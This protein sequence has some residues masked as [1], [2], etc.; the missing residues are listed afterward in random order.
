MKAL[1]IP[2]FLI[3]LLL[4]S[5]AFFVDRASDIP[6]VMK[7]VAP[8]YVNAQ[9]GIQT[10][11]QTK[12][13]EPDDKGFSELAQ[14]FR[15]YLHSPKSPQAVSQI[16]IKRLTRGNVSLS[17]GQNS[18]EEL[19]PIGV[20]LSNG[21]ELTLNIS[22]LRKDIAALQNKNLFLYAFITFFSGVLI[23]CIAFIIERSEN[24]RPNPSFHSDAPPA[25]GCHPL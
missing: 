10:L 6:H 14:V 13:L 22:I 9:L 18:V 8:A 24:K 15:K 12:M 4:A 16:T 20:F 1:S 19:I 17:F 5:A 25:S 3:G 7:I 23:Q 11:K 2:L 21:Q